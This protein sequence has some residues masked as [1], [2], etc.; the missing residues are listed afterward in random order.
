M[1]KNEKWP[2]E[3]PPNFIVLTTAD[4]AFEGSDILYVYHN[5]DDGIWQF[6]SHLNPSANEAVVAGLKEIY[7]IDNSISELANLPLGYFAYRQ[8]KE[9]N[10]I[11]EKDEEE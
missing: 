2:F 1:K 6:H 8:S 11:I 5:S 7:D 4:V 10:W 3:D 9:E